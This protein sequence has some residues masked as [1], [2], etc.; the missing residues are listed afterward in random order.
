MSLALTTDRDIA[1]F[2]EKFTATENG[3][4]EWSAAID[5]HGYGRFSVKMGPTRKD[6][7]MKLAHR[8]SYETYVGKIPEGLDLDHL[9]RNRKC[10]NPGHLEPV[11]RSENL[12][13]SPLM[14]RA[15]LAKT[16]CPKGHPYNKENTRIGKNG[17]RHCKAC[18]AS[19][20]D[21]DKYNPK[22]PCEGCGQVL[23]KANLKK[24][25]DR[26]HR[27]RPDIAAALQ[28]GNQA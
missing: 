4:W 9:C 11:T 5:P 19:H 3:C 15:A 26:Y 18:D 17:S 25:A 8:V 6:Y 24:H 20:W 22:I 16:E 21:T 14:G 1:R 23:R 27:P 7:R 12:R 10:V 28:I 13:R 2:T